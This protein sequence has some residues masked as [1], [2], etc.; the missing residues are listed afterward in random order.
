ML[1]GSLIYVVNKKTH[2]LVNKKSMSLRMISSDSIT[3][4]SNINGANHQI[5]SNNI[6]TLFSITGI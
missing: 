4:C 5:M 3:L 6:I 2:V 1:D